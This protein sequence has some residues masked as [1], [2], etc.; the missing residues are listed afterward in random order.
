MEIWLI[1]NI[2]KKPQKNK[3]QG[4]KLDDNGIEPKNKKDIYLSFN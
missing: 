1:R 4:K 2:Q 3:R